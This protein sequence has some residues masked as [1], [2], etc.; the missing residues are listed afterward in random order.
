LPRYV[1]HLHR[2]ER[3]ML[4]VPESEIELPPWIADE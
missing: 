1:R 3:D 2:V 4:G